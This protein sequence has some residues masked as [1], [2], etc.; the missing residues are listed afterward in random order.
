MPLIIAGVVGFLLICLS[1]FL[2][3]NYTMGILLGL[4]VLIIILVFRGK[5]G[6]KLWK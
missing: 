4:F 6:S 1:V 5:S 3:G 2:S